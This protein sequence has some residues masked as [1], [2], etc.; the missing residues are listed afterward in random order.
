MKTQKPLTFAACAALITSASASVTIDWVTVGNAGNAADPM[1]GF[2]AVAY[3]Y[4]IGKYEVTNAQYVA[5]LNAKAATDPYGLYW[6]TGIT[7]SGSSGSYTYSVSSSLVNDPVVNVS[8]YNAARF[9][10]WMSNGQGDGDTENGS[11]SLLGA[12]S[13][14]ITVN[15]GAKI[16][17]PTENE[18][19]KAAYYNPANATYSLYPNGQNT[20]TAADANYNSSVGSTTDVGTYS[21][22]PSSYGT[23][24][25]GGNVWEWNDAVIGSNRGMRGG[26]WY[27]SG[28]LNTSNLGQ[29][30][31]QAKMITLGFRLASVPEPS[32][33][34]LSIAAGGIILIR[35]KR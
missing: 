12:T 30:Y 25:Q 1:T 21:A 11:Y 35:R 18:W 26:S 32:S 7:R 10:N 28:G 8:W 29:N 23:F 2:G 24:D 4:K 5:F 9:T 15:T 34:L 19:Y 17:I 3:E 6:H 31:P 20:I 27:D 13:G 16:Y 33:A 14:L 22:D